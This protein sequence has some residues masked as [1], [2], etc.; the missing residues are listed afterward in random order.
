M[1][2]LG[3][4]SNFL[5]IDRKYSNIEDSKIVIL[6]APYEHTVSYGKGAAYGP[7][8]ILRASA[9]VEFYDDEFDR[10]L[11][12]ETG[13]AT[14]EPIKF[15]GMVN[16]EA[17]KL[18]EEKVNLLLEKDKFVVTLGGEHTISSAPILSHFKKYPEMTLLH[19]DAHSDL[20]DSYEGS[21]YSHACVM[22]RVCEFFPADR[23][24]QVGIRAQCIEE[25]DFIKKKNIKTYYASSIRRKIFGDNW[26]KEIVKNLGDLIYISFDI[27]YFDPSVIP[28]TGTPEPD[29]F[30]YSETLDIFREIISARKR[31]IGF[32]VV[33]LSKIDGLTHPSLTTA[34]LV[35]KILNFA[36]Y[37][38]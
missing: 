10:E 30:F 25:A 4:D 21:A 32:D 11:C 19:F 34:R 17:L 12:F 24:V 28:A 13:I 7:E 26:Q 9:F 6:P 15:N 35:Y 8:E 22:A 37:G 2:E 20:R 3:S 16:K 18:I 38:S 5:A 29:G 36:F 14:L 23:I 33:E 31:I 27:D 1:K